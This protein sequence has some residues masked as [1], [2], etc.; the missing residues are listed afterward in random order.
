MKRLAVLW[1]VGLAAGL[2]MGAIPGCGSSASNTVSDAGGSGATG[3]DASAGSGG[4]GG[5]KQ[6]SGG[7][8]GDKQGSGGQGSGG[9]GSGGQGSGGQ[10]G[11]A[12]PGSGPLPATAVFYQDISRAPVDAESGKIMTALAASTAWPGLGIDVSMT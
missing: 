9:Q 6:G 8:G 10:G 7:Q 11:A 1:F 3:D 2:G 12:Q 4:Q 5:D